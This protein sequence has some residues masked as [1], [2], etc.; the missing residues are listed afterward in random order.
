MIY[1]KVKVNYLFITS[2]LT[3]Y[4]SI[5]FKLLKLFI[6]SLSLSLSLSS[7]S[8]S[9]Q[10]PL[11][12][13]RISATKHITEATSVSEFCYS[14][15]KVCSVFQ[16]LFCLRFIMVVEME[17]IQISFKL[18]SACSNFLNNIGFYFSHFLTFCV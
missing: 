16:L 3:D 6:N 11:F 8:L 5:V 13:C 9:L 1:I 7:L 4:Q 18:T 14:K 2:T 12:C 17:W 15:Q 10:K